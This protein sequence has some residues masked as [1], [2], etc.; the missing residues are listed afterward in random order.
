M[1]ENASEITNVNLLYLRKARGLA[2]LSRF[3][4]SNDG[5]LTVSV[6]DEMEVRTSHIVRFDSSGKSQILYTFS[7]ETLRKTEITAEGDVFI[8]TTDDDLY[9]FQQARKNRFLPDRRATYTDIALAVDGKRFAVAFSD[10]IVSS[11]SI[12]LG[13]TGGRLLWTKDMAFDA[14]CIAMNRASDTIAVGGESGE[15]ELIST[16]RMPLYTHRQESA[17]RRVV[18]NGIQ[19]TV[20]ASDKGVG[21]LDSKGHLV[22]F[23]ETKGAPVALCMDFPLRTIGVLLQADES[24]GRLLFL[25]GDGLPVW[26]VDFDEARPVSLTLSENGQFAAVTLRDGRISLFELYYGE[27]LA[28]INTEQILLT[29]QQA[30]DSGSFAASADLLRARLVAVPSDTVSMNALRAVLE[31]ARNLFLS[32]AQMAAYV[33]D[34]RLAESKIAEILALDPMDFGAVEQRGLFRRDWA[35]AMR[36]Q[37]E[38]ALAAGDSAAAE[39]CLLEAIEATPLD[40]RARQRLADVRSSAA[41]TALEKGRSCLASGDFVG[42]VEGLVHAQTFG[43]S[44]LALTQLLRTARAGEALQSGNE[45]YRNRQYAAAL[46]Q[47]KKALRFDPENNEARQK[48]GY[49]QNFLQDKDINERFIRLE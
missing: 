31:R 11:H 44:G 41:E 13:E 30:M 45:L 47:F 28:G 48:L 15:I 7:V 16:T 17:V 19:E 37:A 26:D 39:K 8:G 35:E 22:W 21:L 12:A 10:M 24:S 40:S 1:L 23:V 27:R 43:A 33:G 25:T 42:A 32:S 6:P 46:F 29:A 14:I 3:A 4:L 49:A 18:T 2:S 36:L 5:R 20:F 9:L 38:S 34:F